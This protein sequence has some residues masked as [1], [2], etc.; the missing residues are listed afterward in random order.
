VNLAVPSGSTPCP[1]V[2][3]KDQVMS[4]NF[5]N[6]L[7]FVNIKNNTSKINDQLKELVLNSH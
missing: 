1:W 2:A 7:N 6:Q 5:F 3:L 4:I